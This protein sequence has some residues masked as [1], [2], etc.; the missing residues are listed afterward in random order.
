MLLEQVQR[1][2]DLRRDILGRGQRLLL[3]SDLGQE[4][5]VGTRRRQ[6]LVHFPQTLTKHSGEI[7]QFAERVVML[8]LLGHGVGQFITKRPFEVVLG[9]FPGV[10][11]IAQ[12][13]LGDHQQI[14][15]TRPV[16]A[17]HGPQ[18]W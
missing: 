1:A 15:F 17:H 11:L 6:H 4:V 7:F 13:A 2:L 3:R 5:R 12:V 8:F 9:P 10:A 18:Q 16:P 14:I